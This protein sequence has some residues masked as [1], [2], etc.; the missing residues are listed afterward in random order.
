MSEVGETFRYVV[1]KHEQVPQAHYDL[2][3]ENKL[4]T[5]L[6]S[7]RVADWPIRAHT[8][9]ERIPPHRL[10]YLDYEGAIAGERGVVRR[11]A[12]GTCTTNIDASDSFLLLLDDG[13]EIRIPR[14]T[15]D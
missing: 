5:A 15:A 11:V 1:L 14:D 9:V 10:L 13:Q 7:A 2:M 8:R 4:R 3:F 6:L 12:Q